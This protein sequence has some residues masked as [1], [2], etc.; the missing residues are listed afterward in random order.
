MFRDILGFR[1]D[2][3]NDEAYCIMSMTAFGESTDS[4]VFFT[5]KPF[6]GDLGY[7]FLMRSY[8]PENG[9]RVIIKPVPIRH[10]YAR[11]S[12]DGE[13]VIQGVS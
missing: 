3:K 7:A 6:V 4:E 5:G 11:I 13:G 8:R 12:L 10:V 9:L 1:V 2:V